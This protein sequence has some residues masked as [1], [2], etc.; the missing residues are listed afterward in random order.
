MM[1]RFS[2]LLLLVLNISLLSGQDTNPVPVKDHFVTLQE[3]KWN[4]GEITVHQDQRIRQLVN[5]HIEVNSKQKPQGWRIVIFSGLGY[6]TREKAQKV[7]SRFLS[8][9]ENVEAY[10]IYN[11]PNY[12]VHVGDFRIK[13]EAL[14]LYKSLQ[15]TFPGAYIIKD[16]IKYPVIE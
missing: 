13:S 12:K 9:T 5:T 11:E 7:R 8:K 6:G 3:K 2:L 10:L 14:K 15:K 16:C 1:T 4:Q